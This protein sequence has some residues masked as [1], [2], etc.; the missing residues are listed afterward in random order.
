MSRWTAYVDESEPARHDDPGVYLL[1]AALVE[2]AQHES[3]TT[4][5][6]SW[7]LP[8]QRK[9]HWH[10]ES[11]ERRAQLATAVA[12]FDV[13]HLVVV[14]LGGLD[15]ERSERRRRLCLQRL[16]AELEQ[17]G[18]D[19]VVLEARQRKQNLA[20][21]QLLAAMRAQKRLTSALRMDHVSGPNEPVL[22]LADIVCGAVT[23]DRGGHSDYLQT[24]KPLV[25][26]HTLHATDQV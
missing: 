8:G 26:L 3:L 2:Q 13:L 17:T 12:E 22:A 21:Q 23:A 5:V 10:N 1:A 20:D 25:T 6:R 4:A 11:A 16:L 18:I 7:C 15:G 14:R 9:L 24:L 19:H